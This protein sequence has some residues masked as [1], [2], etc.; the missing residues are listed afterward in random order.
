MSY[1]IIKSKVMDCLTTYPNKTVHGISKRVHGSAAGIP[2]EDWVVNALKSCKLNAFLQEEFIEYVINEMREPG[3]SSKDVK[4][5]IFEETWWGSYIV[6]ES[7]LEAVLK[8]KKPRIYQQSL[9]DIIIFY[10]E[11]ISRD[12]ND[13][14]IINGLGHITVTSCVA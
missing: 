11:D 7:Q 9:A 14:L 2:F 5:I 3:F 8:G 4:N 13:V 12:L 10:G 1:E 6:S